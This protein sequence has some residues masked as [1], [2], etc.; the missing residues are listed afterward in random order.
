MQIENAIVHLL[1]KEQHKKET[2]IKLGEAPLTINDD[3]VSLIDRLRKLYNEKATLGYGKFKDDQINYPLSGLLAKHCTNELDFLAWSGQAMTVL[4]KCID[5]AATGGHV[6]FVRYTESATDFMLIASL[7][8]R[9]GV[10]FNEKLELTERG[11]I[12]LDHVH[13]MARINITSWQASGDRYLS[14]A[15]GRTGRND[16]TQYFRDFIG[17]DEFTESKALTTTLVRALKQYGLDKGFA[18]DAQRA[19]DQ[20]V[21]D[22]LE[23][24]RGSIVSLDALSR[25]LSD[26]EPD[27]FKTYLNEN[28]DRFPVS[29]G[30]KPDRSAYRSLKRVSLKSQAISISFD[31]GL[32]GKQV[33]YSSAQGTLLIKELS[34]EFK[35]QLDKA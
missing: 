25:R 6:I 7:K 34:V 22:Y 19:I 1:S 29:D 12:D 30:F 14:F 9:A 20:K 18:P 16:F 23:E 32:L 26:D 10:G 15:K 28:A 21:Y 11:H 4:D 3:L 13:E 17:C 27:A 24:H 2:L 31:A 5:L 8:A 33:V 35:N